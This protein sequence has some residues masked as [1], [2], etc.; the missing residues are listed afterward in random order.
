MIDPSCIVSRLLTY[1]FS[2]IAALHPA[3]NVF[4]VCGVCHAYYVVLV[5]ASVLVVVG[6]MVVVEP[7]LGEAVGVVVVRVGASTAGE[8]PGPPK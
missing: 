6:L 5:F 3:A 2:S 1:L 7:L 4:F 8:S